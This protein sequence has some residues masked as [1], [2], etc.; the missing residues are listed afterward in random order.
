MDHIFV[1]V[2]VFPL[3]TADFAAAK[4]EDDS[5]A[6]GQL[7]LVADEG[8]HILGDLLVIPC[9]R[10]LL[11]VPRAGDTVKGIHFERP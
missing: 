5:E 3:Q 8:P 7:V 1:K 9:R 10:R 11:R 2:H 6:E 4:A